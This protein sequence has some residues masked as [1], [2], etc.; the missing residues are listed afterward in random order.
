[1][2]YNMPTTAEVSRGQHG[3]LHLC[4]CRTPECTEL[5]EVPVQS[6]YRCTGTDK[7]ALIILLFP[8]SFVTP[9]LIYSVHTGTAAKA[10]P[11]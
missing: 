2:A 3:R 11:C 4:T 9:K 5:E 8:E 7:S 10:V 1:M 6:N